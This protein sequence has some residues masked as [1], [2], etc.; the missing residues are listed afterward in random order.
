[1]EP[2]ILVHPPRT[3]SMMIGAIHFNI[4]ILIHD[5]KDP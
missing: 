3:A 5:W 4:H 1:M 2:F